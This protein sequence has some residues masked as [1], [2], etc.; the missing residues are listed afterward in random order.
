MIHRLIR[1]NNALWAA[2]Y[3][4]ELVDT[5][6]YQLTFMAGADAGYYNCAQAV[7]RADD[8]VVSAIEAFYTAR[9]LLPA[10]YLDPESAPGLPSLLAAAGYAEIPAEAEHGYALELHAAPA[11]PAPAAV[12][13]VPLERVHVVRLHGPDDPLLP[14]FLDVDASANA[15]P[16]RV[17]HKLEHKLRTPVANV[18]VCCLLALLDGQPAASCVVGLVGET[19]IFAEAATLPAFRRLGLLSRLMLDGLAI[20]RSSGA[21]VAFLTAATDAASNP[22]VHKLG[23]RRICTRTYM[24]RRVV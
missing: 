21:R 23:F 14:A 17:R 9:G 16:D 1:A 8:D 2:M 24:Q 19:A 22:A 4:D 5:S 10:V 13:H 3:Y 20:A 6:D 18:E 12:L 11:D 7:S 15:L